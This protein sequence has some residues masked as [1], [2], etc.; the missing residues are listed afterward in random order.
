MVWWLGLREQDLWHRARFWGLGDRGWYQ[1]QGHGLGLLFSVRAMAK[2]MAMGM[3][4]AYGF[5]VWFR[6]IA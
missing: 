2:D 1:G 5:W 3:A 6:D 4:M